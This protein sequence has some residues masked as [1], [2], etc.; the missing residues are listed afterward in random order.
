MA[1]ISI[2][3]HGITM[4]KA[5][6][7][8]FN[9]ALF[10]LVLSG[11][12]T[13]AST[14]GLDLPAVLI[15]G[16]AL[17]FRGYL[18]LTQR[19]F[20]IPEHFTSYLTLIYVLVYF[21]DYFFLSGSFLTSTVHLVLFLM[22]VRL[23]SQQRTR[24]HYMLAVLSF[25]MVL[26]SAVL[27]VDSTF[28]FAFAGFLLVAVVTFVLMEMRHSV[29]GG[30]DNA[31][32][33][34][35]DPPV[36]AFHQ[37]MAYSLLAI[38]PALMLL[39][40]AGSFFIFF[41]LPRVSSRYLTA[42][43]PSSDISTG[44]TDKLQLGRI[45]QIQQSSAV[46]MHIE[47]ENDVQG[48]YDLKWR[49]VALN[50]FN[51]NGWS[52]SF[53]S[54]QLASF[55]DGSYRLSPPDPPGSFAI[56][57]RS[58]HYRV[59]MEPIGTNVF[60]LAE[61]PRRLSGN[62]RPVSIDA[63]GAVYDLDL[64]HPINRYDAESDLPEV[65]A[66][67][68]RLATNLVPERANEYLKLP[69]LDLRISQLAEQIT[70]AS[71]SNYDKALAI[72]QYL[73]TRFGYTLELPRTQPRDPLANFLFE[74]KQGHCEYFASSMAVMLRTLGIP[75]RIVNGFRSGEFNDLTGQY[76]VRASNAHSWVEAYF[77][78]SGWI[79]FDPT[80]AG[81]VPTHTGWSRVQLYVDAAAS[82][83][84]EWI[85]NYDSNHQRVLG[86]DAASN[87][88]RLFDE[89]RQWIA[90]QHRALLRSARRAHR[91]VTNFPVRWIG[92]L[93]A[94]AIVLVALFNLRRLLRALRA[95][96]LR[97]HPERAP[98][99][100]AALWYERMIRRMAKLGWR[101]SPSQTPADFVAAIQEPVLRK[102]VARFTRSYESARFGRSVDDAEALPKLFEEITAEQKE[103]SK[104]T[105]SQAAS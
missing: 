43:A 64:E 78:G 69:P 74:R 50:T 95:R 99:E 37:R 54:R 68:L 93:V 24:D 61:K 76:V 44:F 47:I 82:F 19:D 48:A 25:L 33:I 41:F 73:R 30:R 87:I 6:E 97:A 22:V 38:A 35:Q 67:Q 9:V 101:K 62:Y 65:D 72:E 51:G 49:G 7:R 17:L 79:S 96:N 105:P 46:V 27:T 63:G 88:R 86:K 36:A 102:N 53:V 80:P 58:I 13:L 23:F 42:Y 89:F 32:A 40:L 31:E 83:W 45:G 77:P 84:R 4:A 71:P 103:T 57:R 91:H 14:G 70:A 3:P 29:A 34:A 15:V 55:G 10:L 100:S 39:I 2:A 59:L 16:L 81:S 1:E 11:F 60:F 5:I 26:A 92:S 20:V 85:I 56:P 66:D 104:S 8:Y 75:S 90:Q 52:N 98:R 94:L 21:A 28:V 12:G 18:L